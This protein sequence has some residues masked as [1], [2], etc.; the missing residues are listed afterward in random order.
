[1]R[2]WQDCPSRPYVCNW[3]T[4][5][6]V[7]EAKIL[8][9]QPE[10]KWHALQTGWRHF[11]FPPRKEWHQK[12]SSVYCYTRIRLKRSPVRY[13]YRLYFALF[14]QNIGIFSLACCFCLQ[15]Q[16][17]AT[18]T[19]TVQLSLDIASPH[20]PPPRIGFARSDVILYLSQRRHLIRHLDKFLARTSLASKGNNIF[21]DD[22]SL[23][24]HQLNLQ[25]WKN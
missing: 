25:R 7:Q 8:L 10:D 4:T 3:L 22:A 15:I 12:T 19:P 6:G 18:T 14:L 17:P 2:R 16:P 9:G 1:M 13:K 5:V 21:C 11:W 24:N 20:Q 23:P